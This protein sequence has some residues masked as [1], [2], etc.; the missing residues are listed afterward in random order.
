MSGTEELTWQGE[1]HALLAS[2]EDLAVARKLLAEFDD[3]LG[4][5]Y[6]AL[7]DGHP[8]ATVRTCRPGHL[9]G[10]ALVVD[11]AG[12]N[13]LLMLH[14]KFGRWL[15]PGGHADGDANLAAVALREATEETGIDGLRIWPRPL[16]LDIHEVD[17]PGEDP[18][19]HFDVRFLVQAPAG[20]RPQGN[21]E[22]RA[23]RWVPLDG[24]ADFG[25]DPGLV[26]LAQLGAEALAE[27]P[28]P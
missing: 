16:H 1:G 14:A 13:T 23:L 3:D 7:I 10:S 17:P 20:A 21:H 5:R 18:H 26:H 22:S 19:L 6:R 25:C 12:T 24:L 2:T 11:S 15:Q 8:D 9:T 28:K 27:L 4:D